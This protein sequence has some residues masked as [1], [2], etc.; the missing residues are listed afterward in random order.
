[1]QT[2][3]IH[4]E[5]GATM[6]M[7]TNYSY[8]YNGVVLTLDHVG[9]Q[10]GDFTVLKD[11]NAEVKNIVRPGMS[12]GQVVAL[13]GPSG[14]GKTQLFRRLSGL[15]IPGGTCT[16]N[17]WLGSEHT[18]P[19]PNLVGVVA[20]NYPLFDH[21][22]VRGNLD[23]AVQEGCPTVESLLHDF[24]LGD[25]AEA[26]PAQL[27][28]GQRQRVAIAQQLVCSRYFMLMDEPFSGLDPL[29]T[30]RV[31]ELIQ[32]VAARDEYN[33]IVLV[34]HDISSAISVA[35]HLWVL[36]RDRAPDGTV[37]PGAYIKRSY[38]LAAM[39]L[40]WHPDIRKMP[41]FTTLNNEIRDLFPS[42]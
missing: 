19:T 24:D 41:E 17:V 1:M 39:G 14:I 20:Q 31:I 3:F 34:T 38:D 28:G 6:T 21:R 30:V 25:H 16:G 26:Y 23:V 40:C 15:T 7:E 11:V 18:A 10:F 12:Q 36:G 5:I 13:L 42:L 2:V 29:M 37:I 27:S 9:L 8:S 32:K 22:T 33:T 4:Q 35:D